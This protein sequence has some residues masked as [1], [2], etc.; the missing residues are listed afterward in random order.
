[1][2][3]QPS[4]LRLRRKIL[5]FAVTI[6]GGVAANAAQISAVAGATTGAVTASIAGNYAVVNALTNTDNNDQITITV[7]DAINIAN[8]NTLNA[9]TA[10]NLILT[11]GV[12]DEAINLVNTAGNA[13]TAGSLRLRRKILMLQLQ[14]QVV[15]LPMLHK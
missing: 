15:M 6:T 7:N 9:K 10:L 3:R 2:Q 12:S 5:M 13:E 11:G 1:M 8:V 14:L 4:S